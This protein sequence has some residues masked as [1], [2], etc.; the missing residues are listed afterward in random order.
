[1]PLAGILTAIYLAI[2]VLAAMLFA[3]SAAGRAT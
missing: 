1:V 2:V 3:L